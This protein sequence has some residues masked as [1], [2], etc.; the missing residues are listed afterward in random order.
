MQSK[1][2]A[3]DSNASICSSCNNS[4]MLDDLWEHA[5]SELKGGEAEGNL[6]LARKLTLIGGAVL[7]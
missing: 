1:Q 3:K 6:C 4:E 7:L 5:S 2:D